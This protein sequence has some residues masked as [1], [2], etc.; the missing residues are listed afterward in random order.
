MP[1]EL[2]ERDRRFRSLP[3]RQQRFSLLIRL[4][5]QRREIEQ[6]LTDVE[7]FE[8]IVDPSAQREGVVLSQAF[9]VAHLEP[10]RLEQ[11]HHRAHVM[12]FAIGENV[13]LDELTTG[14]G[15]SAHPERNLHLSTEL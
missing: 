4:G 8:E 7:A 12:Q 11:R 5:R 14:L 15:R 13:A 9:E 2:N 6:W 1:E 3:R 10:V